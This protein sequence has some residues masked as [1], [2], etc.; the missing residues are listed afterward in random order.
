M[1]LYRRLR[2]G[3]GVYFFTVNLQDRESRLLVDNIVV[4][5]E[6]WHTV[7]CKHPFKT[8]AYV[9]LPDHLHAMWQLP[10]DDVDYSTRIRLIKKYFTQKM[11]AENN[12]FN[13]NERGEYN[14]WQKR[15]WEHVIRDEKDYENHANYI[16]YNPIKHRLVRRSRDWMHSSF[17]NYV[18]EGV[19]PID[20]SD[21]VGGEFLKYDGE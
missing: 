8:I 15:Y 7:K 1:V 20:W 3:G 5:R 6:A 10:E 17:L 9:I 14:I 13:R 21:G 18:R 12:S 16:H 2:V 19:Y 4:L 11:V